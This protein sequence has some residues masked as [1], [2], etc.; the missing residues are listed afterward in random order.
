MKDKN[1]SKQNQEESKNV[2]K[3]SI[4]DRSF[5]RNGLGGHMSRA[6]PGSSESYQKKK[7]IRKMREY[8]RAILREAQ[9]RYR[10]R[11]GSQ[12][13]KNIEMNRAKLVIIKDEVEKEW[14]AEKKQLL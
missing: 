1:K 2:Y 9:R 7:D 3:C 4:C 12:D 14:K 11:R 6:H 8:N 10:I 13:I 5:T